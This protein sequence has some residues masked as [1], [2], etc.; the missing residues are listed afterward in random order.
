MG[1]SRVRNIFRREQVP[2]KPSSFDTLL[3]LSPVATVAQVLPV[4]KKFALSPLLELS[5]TME[6]FYT[7]S[8]SHRSLSLPLDPMGALAV[9]ASFSTPSGV[10]SL[11]SVKRK[12]RHILDLRFVVFT[13][14]YF[15][16]HF[17]QLLLTVG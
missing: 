3:H 14:F 12:I 8:F 9:P 6:A 5:R 2:P 13:I 16:P 7:L 1:R 17:T 15:V 10:V 4:A 11:F